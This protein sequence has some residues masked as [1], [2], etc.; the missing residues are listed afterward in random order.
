MSE[1]RT[2]RPML[3]L[4]LIA[5][6]L[7]SAL[8]A[9]AQPV[10]AQTGAPRLSARPAPPAT[11]VETTIKV[12]EQQVRYL[13]AGSGPTTIVLLHGWPQSSHEWR[14][15][16][17]L[18]ADRYTVIAPDLRG[19]GGTSA[20]SASFEK[21]TLARD[22]H[23]LITQLGARRVIMVGHDIGGMVAYAYARLYPREIVGLSILDVPL[24]GVQPWEAVKTSAKAW[25]FDFHTQA[26]LAERLVAG[27]QAEYFRYMID[28]VSVRDAA[29]SDEDI[30]TYAAAYRS[31]ESL[32]AGFAWYRAFSADETFNASR[33]E[34]LDVPVLLVGGDQSMGSSLS[35]VEQGLRS[36]GV[37]DIRLAV[38][39]N[40]GHHIAEEDPLA[41]AS[42]IATFASSLQ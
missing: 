11:I 7:V 23:G 33:R 2:G 20:P 24:P 12:G 38:I 39:A 32:T 35:Q 5:V 16:M 42:T 27:R 17:P 34:R 10:A 4:H 1:E 36:L 19:V 13:K 14:K 18:L 3:N 29:I 41:T 26:P 6:L 31:P 8:L 25:H 21:T 40:A 9:G 37:R 30:A 15:V 22:V 28:S